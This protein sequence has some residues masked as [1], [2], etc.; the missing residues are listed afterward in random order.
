MKE[1]KTVK[2]TLSLK[3][4]FTMVELIFVIVIV[5]ILAKFGADI[6]TKVYMNYSHSRAINTLESRTEQVLEVMA[7][8]L[9]NRIARSTVAIK[10]DK[11]KISSASPIRPIYTITGEEDILEWYG[12]AEEIKIIA[13]TP[14]KLG[15]SGFVDLNSTDTQYN[16]S[17]SSPGSN[18]ENAQTYMTS[19]YSGAEKN[20]ALVFDSG[21]RSSID[22]IAKDYGW[23]GNQAH[24]EVMV[25]HYNGNKF[26][27][28]EKSNL[29]NT[30]SNLYKRIW[31]EY[32]IA[33]TAYAIV[34]EDV[35]KF[36][37]ESKMFNL[38]IYYNYQPWKNGAKFETGKKSLLADNVSLFRFREENGVL[39]LK[40]CMRD[41]NKNFES[42]KL[43]V[44]ACKV[45]AV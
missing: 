37:G 32:N 11:G 10:S 33:Y 36:I 18:I 39:Y 34:P 4:A 12:S 40:I 27:L 42:K 14:P 6:Y 9:K 22:K 25:G 15:W 30:Y 7:S 26:M 8:K 31:E 41:A 35:D 3:R 17:L 28:D 19:L 20:L 2:K 24:N 13:G 5:G 1:S 21:Y 44:I 45:K 43:D 29:P 16:V 23:L 38:Y